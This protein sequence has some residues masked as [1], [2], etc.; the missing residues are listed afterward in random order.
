MSTQKS[1]SKTVVERRRLYID[2]NCWLADTEALT[3]FTV[4]ITPLTSEAPLVVDVAFTDVTNRKLAV[5]V[6]AGKGNTS[7]V[8]QMIV[9][10]DAGQT[11][12]DDVNIRV[13][14]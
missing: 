7:Y 2:Y 13:L 10:T 5:Y 14:P 1:F 12:R 8:V 6:D 11:K 3:N 4:V 9:D